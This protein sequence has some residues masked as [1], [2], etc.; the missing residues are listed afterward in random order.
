MSGT[1]GNMRR[2]PS[3]LI[4]PR[5]C[6]LRARVSHI[7]ADDRQCDLPG[8]WERAVR[9]PA[10]RWW[11]SEE[12]A[13]QA[14]GAWMHRPD[15]PDG[16]R[17]L[18]S[19]ERMYADLAA[20]YASRLADEPEL[21]CQ[22][23]VRDTLETPAPEYYITASAARR[24]AARTCGNSVFKTSHTHEKTNAMRRPRHHR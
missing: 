6:E 23:F 3:E 5:D 24:S 14:V 18:T 22:Q 11:I 10:S 8:A 4:G 21:S 9:Q 19:R 7:L 17:R 15:P 16:S 1:T 20:L 2:R 12:R 13:A